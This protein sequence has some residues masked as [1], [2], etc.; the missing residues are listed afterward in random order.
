MMFRLALLLVAVLAASGAQAEIYKC[1][2]DDG[3]ITY[4]QI[5]CPKQKTTTVRS[6]VPKTGAVVDC[7]W[8]SAFAGDVTR[9][10]RSGLASEALF[11]FYGGIDSVSPGTINIINYVYRF[12]GN[13]SVPE[14][15]I[16]SLAGSMCKAGSLG[17]VRCEALPY[18]QD[19]GGRCDDQEPDA[20]PVESIAPAQALPLAEQTNIQQ[21]AR[22]DV[23][24]DQCKK[25]IRDQIDAI[26]AQMR[27][28]YDSAQGERYRER[29]RA[30]TTRLH[31]C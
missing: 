3:G 19:P 16:S 29:L 26:D 10:M 28:G 23:S 8:A 24:N 15:R 30:L 9:R 12:R 4:S 31:Q 1:V 17:D 13:E 22:T 2:A 27:T 20:G 21:Q 25:G 5:P 6:A 14:Q 11:D 7:R 18:G